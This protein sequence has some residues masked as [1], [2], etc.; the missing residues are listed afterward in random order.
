MHM[1][2]NRCMQNGHVRLDIHL[3]HQTAQLLCHRQQ[4]YQ[5]DSVPRQL[6]QLAVHRLITHRAEQDLTI[7]HR[8]NGKISIQ[9]AL[10]ENCVVFQHV[11]HQPRQHQIH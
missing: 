11:Q 9:Q 8:A 5:T 1:V 2:I 4:L 3:C 10:L 6:Q 7:W